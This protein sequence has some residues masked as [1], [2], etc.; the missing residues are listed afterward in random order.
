MGKENFDHIEFQWLSLFAEAILD[1]LRAE[2]AGQ[3]GSDL[4]DAILIGFDL[5]PAKWKLLVLVHWSL[6]KPKTAEAAAISAGLAHWQ[7]ERDMLL[8]L[9]RETGTAQTCPDC[10]KPTH[11]SGIHTCSPQVAI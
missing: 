8:K 1:G 7:A 5:D 2:E 11:A 6:S 3:F 9:I 10:H 4:L